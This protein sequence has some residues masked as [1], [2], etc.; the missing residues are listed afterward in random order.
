LAIGLDITILCSSA[1]VA[2]LSLA[3]PAYTKI[4]TVR[5]LAPAE[6]IG[7]A[8]VLTFVLS[9][10]QL[11]VDWKRLADRYAQAAVAYA[12]AKPGCPEEC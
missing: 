4:L 11:R 9:I 5:D 2:V 8:G 10:I 6:M 1:W 12:T 3:D 7:I